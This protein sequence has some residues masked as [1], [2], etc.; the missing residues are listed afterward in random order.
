M[1]HEKLLGINLDLLLQQTVK[2]LFESTNP[3]A[4]RDELEEKL[5]QEKMSKA[6][7]KSK[8][9]SKKNPSEPAA[10][11]GAEESSSK[12]TKIKHEKI[13]D[14]DAKAIREK[15]D[16]IRAGK[17]LK[18]SE[19]M[20]ALKLYF[21]KL[22]GPERIALYAFLSGLEKILGQQSEKVKA[23]HQAP[24]NIDME[25]DQEIESGKV[26]RQQQGTKEI[27]KTKKSENPIIV[28]EH[29]DTSSIKAKLWRR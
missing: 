16:N 23:P 24:Y 8:A 22:N 3:D 19:T 25:K 7:S 21:Q 26:H 14:I 2:E 15:V 9:R 11:E 18:D 4:T 13:P 28:G 1:N 10:D 5:K 29:A 27:S 20:N 6:V 12:P 17:S